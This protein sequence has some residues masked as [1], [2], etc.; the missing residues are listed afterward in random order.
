VTSSL[1][2]AKPSSIAGAADSY[3]AS[4][5]R[6]HNM[7]ASFGDNIQ[8]V[9][10]EASSELGLAYPTQRALFTPP[11]SIQKSYFM[12]AGNFKVQRPALSSKRPVYSLIYIL[13][14]ASSAIPVEGGRMLV[15]FPG[16]SPGAR[17]DAAVRSSAPTHAFAIP[18]ASAR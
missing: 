7:S 16:S 11:N 17:Q 5:F 4:F 2:L 18:G 3:L 15:S 8:I 10:N 6:V 14:S 9:Y 1:L 12:T 13:L